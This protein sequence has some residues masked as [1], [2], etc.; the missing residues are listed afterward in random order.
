MDSIMNKT[1]LQRKKQ[2][3]LIENNAL[4]RNKMNQKRN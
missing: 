2:Y 1:Q 4:N 3:E